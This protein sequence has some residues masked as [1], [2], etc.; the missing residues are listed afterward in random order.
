MMSM[1]KKEKRPQMVD[2][3]DSLVPFGSIQAVLATIVPLLLKSPLA[4]PLPVSVT[5]GWLSNKDFGVA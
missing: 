5:V 1:R 4:I 2:F 3:K